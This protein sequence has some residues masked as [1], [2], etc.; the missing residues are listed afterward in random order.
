VGWRS[1]I[2]RITRAFTIFAMSSHSEGTSVSLLE[3]M[4]SGL[5]PVVTDVGG[6]SIVLGAELSHRL[7]RPNDPEALAR[8]LTDALRNEELRE[9]DARAARARV[10]DDF[11]LE[12]MVRR[13]E[14]LYTGASDGEGTAD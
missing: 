3:A 11:G 9:R 7:V 10:V 13:Y 1:D 6:N 8:A 2:E 14:T 4:S 12:A 5:C